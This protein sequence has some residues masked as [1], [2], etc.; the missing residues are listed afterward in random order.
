MNSIDIEAQTPTPSRESLREHFLNMK[1]RIPI[2][3][4][5]DKNIRLAIYYVI[6]IVMVV[7][8]IV[9]IYWKIRY[10]P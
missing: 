10:G 1:N 2:A 5:D 4:D 8:D 7:I 9:I 3:R 6:F